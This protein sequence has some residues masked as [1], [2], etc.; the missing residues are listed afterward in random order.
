VRHLRNS[1]ILYSAQNEDPRSERMAL[2][3]KSS[4][5]V[6][7]VSSSGSRVFEV[8]L[9]GPE[10]VI[11]VDANPAQLF[12]LELKMCAC[13]VLDYPEYISFL[14]LQP[15]ARRLNVF[16]TLKRRLSPRAKD[17]WESRRAA[18]DQGVLY[19]GEWERRFMRL[20]RLSL[21]TG[22]AAEM[23]KI[24][25]AGRA[26]EQRM[27]WEVLKQSNSW[28]LFAS[29]LDSPWLLNLLVR[30]PGTKHI[31]RAFRVG[32]YITNRIENSIDHIIFR[33]SPF[34]WLMW[35][36]SYCCECAVPNYLSESSFH[37]SKEL[38]S[39][40][41]IRHGKIRE[42][43][44]ALGGRSI[45]KFSLSDF[46]SYTADEEYLSTWRSIAMASTPGAL[47][48]ERQFMV[49]PPTA[50]RSGAE[51]DRELSRQ[52][53]ADDDS[54]FYTVDCGQVM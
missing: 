41:E 33:N 22:I 54:L 48:C 34:A 15:G 50:A 27:A 51:Q 45:S 52:L 46:S 16:N 53:T 29:A 32:S 11:A 49:R 3:I 8:L 47:Y 10:R 13:E 31:S 19:Q 26:V 37:R 6:L 42:V 38:L 35:T 7:C 40:I 1:G 24:L 5:T 43:C 28:R 39:R 9:S 25:A 14:G 2:K 30:D 23:D 18:V 21:A 36:G 17:F 12:L 44:D 20:R 4:D